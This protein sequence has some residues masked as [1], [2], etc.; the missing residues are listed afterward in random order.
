MIFLLPI[1]CISICFIFLTAAFVTFIITIGY[2]HKSLL[3]KPL[4]G[5]RKKYKKALNF[6]G[7]ALVFAFG[8]HRI[9]R[10]GKRSTKEARLLVAAP[11]TTFLDAFVF[12]ALG[13]SA[14]IPSIVSRSTNINIPVVGY[15]FRLM[16]PIL[17]TREDDS[18]KESTI[19]EIKKRASSSNDWPQVFI[20]PEGT[21]T[22]GSCLISF[23][24]GAF[25]PGE[26]IQPLL[27]EYKNKIDTITWSWIGI[28][29]IKVL[30]L[31]LSQ[32]DN[33]LKITVCPTIMIILVSLMNHL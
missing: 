6:L 5:R 31:T 18:K 2:D 19:D 21:T 26:P 10:A 16:Q 12:L 23:K 33:K 13:Y 14:D 20:F 7:R 30:V 1:R 11:H 29:A 8:F 32:L 28:S 17:V 25:I 15:I 24:N 3:E 4:E 22:N 27:I 9:E